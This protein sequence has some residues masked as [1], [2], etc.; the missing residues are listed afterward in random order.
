[1]RMRNRM[2]IKMMMRRRMKIPCR[3]TVIIGGVH[4][5]KEGVNA[6]EPLCCLYSSYMASRVVLGGTYDGPA[7]TAAPTP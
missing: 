1:M 7:A 5:L 4:A 3:H 2:N 6:A